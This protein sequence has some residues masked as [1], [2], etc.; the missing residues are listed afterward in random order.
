MSKKILIVGAGAVGLVYGSQ[1]AEAG[2]DVN[3][4]IKEKYA[5]EMA[6]GA[7][8]YNINRDKACQQPL[9]FRNY[10]TVIGW[11]QAANTPWDMIFL[12]ISSVALHQ[13]FD[14]DG[15][16]SAIGNGTLVM[17]QPGP[18]D[19]A[20]VKRHIPESQVVQGMITLA[21]YHTPMPGETTAIPGTAY[22]MPP[23]VPTPFAG[24]VN[25]RSEVIQTFIKAKMPSKSTKDL[26]ETSLFSTAFF[27]VFLTALEAAGW[28]FEALRK[29]ATLVEHML[30]ANNEAF[31]AI[32]AKHDVTA[33]FWAKW[34]SPWMV[35]SLL[36]I[37]PHASP[38]DLEMFFQVHFTKVK[39]QTKLFVNSYID[40]AKTTGQSAQ[41]LVLLD[42]YT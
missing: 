26:R 5:D 40:N 31:T 1:F 39:A 20:L 23:F 18:E 32:S 42:S 37:A 41:Q 8:L 33:P 28:K 34:I 14:F 36:K 6:K 22:W 38:F 16:K 35:K 24:P 27:M 19:V 9:H 17:L 25:R 4:L 21:S 15:L 13:G 29:N 10:K 2:F 12:C 30:K 3:F 11:D 7:I